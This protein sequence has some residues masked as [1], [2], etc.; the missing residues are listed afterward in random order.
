MLAEKFAET[1][2]G[3]C[4]PRECAKRVRRPENQRAGKATACR[5]LLPLDGAQVPSASL[6][7]TN[8]LGRHRSPL[9]PKYGLTPIPA[10]L[11]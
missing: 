4:T 6:L 3:R 8:G 10:T 11:C 5:G 9:K 2:P 1:S 7:M